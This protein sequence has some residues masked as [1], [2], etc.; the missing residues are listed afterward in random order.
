MLRARC[1]ICTET[2]QDNA[3]CC[4]C[5]HVYHLQCIDRWITECSRTCPTCRKN[6]SKALLLFFDGTDVNSTQ[7]GDDVDSLQNSIEELKSLLN[8]KDVEINC[9][10]QEHK[11]DLAEHTA[12]LQ[13]QTDNEIEK[14]K[15]QYEKK[16]QLEKSATTGLKKQL[17]Y[18]KDKET[19]LAVAK[20]EAN[21]L[22]E[23]FLQLKRMKVLIDDNSR[24]AEAMLR[25]LD[26]KSFPEVIVQLV[27]LKKKLEEK[28]LKCKEAIDA[29][30]RIKKENNKL[31]IE[32]TQV[33]MELK[34]NK[35]LLQMAEE[36]IRRLEKENSS[37]KKKLTA[38][39]RAFASPSPRSSAIG[40]LIRESPAP[41]DIKRPRLSC[42]TLE[43]ESEN[44]IVAETP[45][46]K[47][48]KQEPKSELTSI[49]EE[50]G[51]CVVKTTSMAS[52]L[53]KAVLK[54]SQ[55]ISRKSAEQA[56]ASVFRRGYDGLGGHTKFLAPTRPVKTASRKVARPTGIS[57]FV[58]QTKFSRPADPPLPVMDLDFT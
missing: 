11:K 48:R 5:G 7:I 54:P 21:E 41:L 4:P 47:P 46:P 35:D 56:G 22:R 58:K 42:P 31:K 39:E 10:K 29:T 55:Q 8:Q 32:S 50:M 49:A 33:L 25:S 2:I 16:L 24:D 43:E 52:P 38:M 37:Y 6:T 28:R 17:T 13:K 3:A 26:S 57:K 14:I 27:T 53:Q 40:R 51:L 9:L 12:K 36:D 30:E 20:N 34:K 23:G 18:L 44:I 1:S 45:S 15:K 19:E